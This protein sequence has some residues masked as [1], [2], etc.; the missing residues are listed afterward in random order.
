MSDNLEMSIKDV[1]AAGVYEGKD[2]PCV[3][4]AKDT[5]NQTD[6]FICQ[7]RSVPD[8]NFRQLKVN[9]S[10]GVGTGV[11]LNLTHCL[12]GLFFFFPPP[13]G[14]VWRQDNHA[15]EY[16]PSVLSHVARPSADP[17]HYCRFVTVTPRC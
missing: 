7:I 14:F 1:S 6:F 5:N 12:T 4:E 11:R 17:L 13:A 15:A 16:I 8:M 2:Y 9:L 3:M 10:G